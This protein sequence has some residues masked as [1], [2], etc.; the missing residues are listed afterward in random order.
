MKLLKTI[1]L[2]KN[3]ISEETKNFRVRN[4]ARA[5]VFD[6]NNKIGLL[7]V[8]NHN[9]HKLPGGGIEDGE[10][11]MKALDREC[12]EEIGCHIKV[13]GKLG[14]IKEYRDKWSL[15]Q[16]SFCYL[17]NVVGKKGKPSFTQKELDGGFE[18]KWVLLDEA[19]KLLK[20][21][22]PNDYEGMYIQIRDLTFLKEAK[23]NS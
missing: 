15:E 16:H 10:N 8:A 18:I 13:S 11:V 9:Y 7:L 4:A 3:L 17:A 12:L 19:I 2:N 6:E 21:D 14:E 23:N 20:A 5:V 22:K 1:Q